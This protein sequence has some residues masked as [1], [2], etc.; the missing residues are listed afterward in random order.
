MRRRK[1]EFVDTTG[2]VTYRGIHG[3]ALLQFPG[4]HGGKQG[5]CLDRGQSPLEW[6]DFPSVR[7][8]VRPY[9]HPSVRPFPPSRAQEPAR[10][11][12]DPASQASEPAR[13][14]SEPL[15]AWLAGSEAWL[16]GSEACLAGSE[17]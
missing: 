2:L 7:T 12:L 11:A 9:I 17:A 6:G 14:A 1:N 3:S 10:Q 16:A 5:S 15:E 13:H 4:F 8:S